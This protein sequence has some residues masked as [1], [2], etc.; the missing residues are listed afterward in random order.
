VS[1]TAVLIVASIAAPSTR[2]FADTLPAT[3]PNPPTTSYIPIGPIRILDTRDEGDRPG[4]GATVVAPI[5]DVQ[6][7]PAVATAAAITVTATD[8]AAPGYITV[9]GGGDRPSTSTLNLDAVGDTHANFA[10]IPLGDDGAIRLFTQS[11]AHL[12]VDV[13]G[14]FVPAEAATTGRFVAL[15]PVRLLDTRVDGS[16]LAGHEVRTV[17][18]TVL[19]VPRSASALVVEVTGISVDGWF[20]VWQAGRPWPGTS[21]VNTGSSGTPTT[22]SA[23]VPLTDGRL[24]LTSSTGGHVVVDVTGWFTGH[25]A[26]ETSDGLFVPISPTRVLDTRGAHGTSVPLGPTETI[27]LN[28]FPFSTLVAGAAALNVT[29]VQPRADGFITAF[30]TATS[31]PVAALSNVAARDVLAAGGIVPMSAIGISIYA[32]PLTHLVVDATGWFTTSARSLPPLPRPLPN[33]STDF[34]MAVTHDDGRWARW[35]PCD[36]IIVLVD[37]S[38]A[39]LGARSVLGDVVTEVRSATGLDLRVVEGHVDATPVDRTITIHWAPDGAAAGLTGN[40][41]GLAG[42]GYT[43]EQIL[44]GQVTV[45][46]DEPLGRQPAGDDLLRFVLAH[47]IAHTLGLGHDDDPAQLMYPYA[48]GHDHFQDGDL[49]GLYLLGTSQGCLQPDQRPIE[50]VPQHP[51]PMTWLST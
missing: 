21:T 42:F 33:A 17:D 39:Q 44:W 3:T 25:D 48:N 31:R 28:A 43:P 37:F 6:G 30:P 16:T 49:A 14:V 8:A 4:A 12:I 11:G 26:P 41:I 51:A 23:I 20:A 32:Q 9:W 24:S 40:V 5:T 45:R 47:E 46:S 27:E 34:T 2:A 19:G 13:T 36:P 29:A 35:D 50:L 18:A 7:I 38:D 1:L 10:L 15:G 22:A